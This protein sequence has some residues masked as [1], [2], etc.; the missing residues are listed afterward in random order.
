MIGETYCARCNAQYF[1]E[2]GCFCEP[3]TP[4]HVVT[5]VP[6]T[7]IRDPDSPRYK[8]G[9]FWGDAEDESTL[10]EDDIGKDGVVPSMEA[11]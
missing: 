8:L 5:P 9:V 6:R 7:V 11:H 3:A 1:D 10:C 4:P 2:L